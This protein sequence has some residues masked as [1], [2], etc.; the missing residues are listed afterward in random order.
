MKRLRIRSRSRQNSRSEHVIAKAD[1]LAAAGAFLR[2]RSDPAVP[3]V[4]LA[5]YHAIF[6]FLGCLHDD[7]F[8]KGRLI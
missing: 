7:K 4:G 2:G 6:K 1:L 5:K 3:V 8:A